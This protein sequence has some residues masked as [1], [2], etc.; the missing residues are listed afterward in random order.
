[1]TWGLEENWF[2]LPTTMIASYTNDGKQKKLK[3]SWAYQMYD[4]LEPQW[5]LFL[6]VNPWKEGLSSNQNQG[7]FGFRVCLR[8]S[9]LE[10]LS[11]LSV[12][13]VTHHWNLAKFPVYIV[14]GPGLKECKSPAFLES[15]NSLIVIVETH[16][17]WI[18]IGIL[19]HRTW[20]W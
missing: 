1:M 4:Y 17:Q 7:S 9:S 16:E 5:P 3:H 18:P 19:A 15:T 20:E 13:P 14:P 6:K 12:H 8:L 10:I 2:L 11:H